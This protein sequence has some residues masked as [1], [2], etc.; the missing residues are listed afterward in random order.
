MEQPK[1]LDKEHQD[2]IDEVMM[3]ATKDVVQSE[4]TDNEEDE[5]VSFGI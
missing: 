2:M 4:V 5:E 1:D 3:N